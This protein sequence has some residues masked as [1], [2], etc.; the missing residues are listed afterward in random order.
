MLNGHITRAV[1]FMQL[2]YENYGVRVYSLCRDG[3]WQPHMTCTKSYVH[4]SALIIVI[5]FYEPYHDISSVF[6]I[7]KTVML[8]ETFAGVPHR[9]VA[10]LK[11]GGGGESGQTVYFSSF[12]LQ[13]G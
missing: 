12:F 5:G 8:L 1:K 7:K 13:P 2:A 3:T 6:T 9:Q 4:Y 11:G 10:T